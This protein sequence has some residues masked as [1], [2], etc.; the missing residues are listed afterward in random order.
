MWPTRTQVE[1]AAY[2]RWQRRGG[3]HGFDD[4]DWA[5]AEDDLIFALNYRSHAPTRL[6]RPPAGRASRK[7]SRRCRFCERAEPIVSFGHEPAPLSGWLGP[8]GPLDHVECDECRDGF[9]QAFETDLEALAMPFRAMPSVRGLLAFPV[10]REDTGDGP[11]SS[12]EVR[13]DGSMAV[14]LPSPSY[15]PV[16]ALKGLVRLALAVLPESETDAFETTFEWVGNPDHA[17]DAHAL[18][19]VSCRVAMTPNPFPGPFVALASK[20]DP[21]A[22]VPSLLAIV[23]LDHAAFQ[24]AVPFGQV[25]ADLDGEHLRAPTITLP[26]TVEAP[27]FEG[28]RIEVRL[29]DAEPRD[30]ASLDLIYRPDVLAGIDLTTRLR[31]ASPSRP[32]AASLLS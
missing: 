22:A 3:S 9:R 15:V 12:R 28:P 27:P 1:L 5:A 11:S 10:Y 17:L 25:D 31:A 16:A 23:G 2:E 18:G 24:F 30:R 6:D 8:V 14:S 20:I 21:D 7:G 4:F 26:G 13:W 32:A 19:G 29:D